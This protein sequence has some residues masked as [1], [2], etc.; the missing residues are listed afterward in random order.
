MRPH[1]ISD[2][3]TINILPACFLDAGDLT[4]VSQLSEADTANAVLAKIS[5]GSSADFT[6][7][8]GSGG[9]FCGTSLLDFH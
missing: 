1:P 8:I 2:C 3:F 7:V 5:M 6:S 4:C 9:I